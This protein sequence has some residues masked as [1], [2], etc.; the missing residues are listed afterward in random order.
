M[1]RSSYCWVLMDFDEKKELPYIVGVW[2]VK[3]ELETY[4][5]NRPPGSLKDAWV[6]R[7]RDG[8]PGPWASWYSLDDLTSGSQGIVSSH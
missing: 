1:A 3:H 2:T 6:E 4:L 7:H 8:K 5:R